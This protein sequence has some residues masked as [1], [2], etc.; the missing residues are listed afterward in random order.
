MAGSG[1]VNVIQFLHALF[2]V[3][4]SQYITFYNCNNFFPTQ[5]G[6]PPIGIEPIITTALCDHDQRDMVQSG[7]RGVVT[8]A[9]PNDGVSPPPPRS[10]PKSVPPPN[11]IL[12]A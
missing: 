6:V 8:R 3:G 12:L 7:K 2:Q 10:P 4:R 1:S 5:F 11:F 9:S